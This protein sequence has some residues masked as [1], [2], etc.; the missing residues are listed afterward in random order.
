MNPERRKFLRSIVAGAGMLALVGCKITDGTVYQKENTKNDY[1]PLGKAV[2][3]RQEKN[4]ER[5]SQ[6]PAHVET[7]PSKEWI[8][9]YQTH[10][11]EEYWTVHIAKCPTGE[12]PP[13]DKIEKECRTNS[14]HVPQEVY[15]KVRIGQHASFKQPQ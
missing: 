12:L 6:P 10:W 11:Q 1:A 2:S 9:G 8:S 15:N 13:Q 4:I 5:I 3:W 14:F 7:G